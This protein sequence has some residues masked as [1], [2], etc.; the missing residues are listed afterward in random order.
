MKR[1]FSLIIALFTALAGLC[2]CDTQKGEGLSVVATNFAAYDFARQI[3]GQRGTVTLLLPPGGESHT[4]EPTAKDIV[5]ISEC[6]LFVYNGGESDSWVDG[7]LSALEKKPETARMM[8]FVDLDHEHEGHDHEI[9]E[10]IWTSPAFAID[11][12]TGISERICSVDGTGAAYYAENA[13]NYMDEIRDLHGDFKELFENSRRKVIVVADRFPFTWFAEEYGLTYY[14]A[15]N[16]CSHDAE[17]TPAVIA[18]LIDTVKEENIPLIFY[19]EFSNRTVATAVSEDTG[20]RTAELH[21]CHSVTKEQLENG[22]TY[23]DL[24]RGNYEVLKE[25]VS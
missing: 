5:K 11:I 18:R 3:V 15:Y 16:S 6:D 2:A 10:H 24:M 22:V 23:L 8:D 9:D 20:A 25:A 13:D 1:V 19:I 17:P 7:I 4:Y 21:S 12:I 14:A